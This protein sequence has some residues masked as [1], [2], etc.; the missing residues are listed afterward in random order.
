MKLTSEVFDEPQSSTQLPSQPQADSTKPAQITNSLPLT[1]ESAS[2]RSRAHSDDGENESE[3]AAVSRNG[4]PVRIH[5]WKKAFAVVTTTWIIGL[6]TLEGESFESFDKGKTGYWVEVRTTL[7]HSNLSSLVGAAVQRSLVTHLIVMPEGE[8]SHTTK[9]FCEGDTPLPASD[10]CSIIGSEISASD[11]TVDETKI[12]AHKIFRLRTRR[13]DLRRELEQQKREKS[14]IAEF[15]IEEITQ[16]LNEIDSELKDLLKE[17]REGVGRTSN[18]EDVEVPKQESDMTEQESQ[19]KIAPSKS[20]VRETQSLD[21]EVSEQRIAPELNRRE[22]Q[23][24]REIWDGGG[25]L[26]VEM[27]EPSI[28]EGLKAEGYLKKIGIIRKYYEFT[29]KGE[30]VARKLSE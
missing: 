29:R 26:K 27:C 22:R 10:L 2:L 12:L 9:M 30:R 7:G 14:A 17:Q 5:A 6:R 8:A 21:S 23:A 20:E 24:I 28:C 13:E 1:T 18:S 4:I 25:K 15:R 19:G 16:T 3:L 11:L